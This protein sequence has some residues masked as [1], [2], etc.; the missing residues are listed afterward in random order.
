MNRLSWTPTY[1]KNFGK[2]NNPWN[3]EPGL[4]VQSSQ[5]DEVCGS[6]QRCA[7][8]KAPGGDVCPK[9][10]GWY[11]YAVYLDLS[12]ETGLALVVKDIHNFG[13]SPGSWPARK[14]WKLR[15]IHL[16]LLRKTLNLNKNLSCT[17]WTQPK[18]PTP[19]R[20]ALPLYSS[21]NLHCFA[22]HTIDQIISKTTL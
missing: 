1:I 21:W 9:L 22:V 6:R 17:R 18:P 13:S 8:P 10:Y 19:S 7:T 11:W 3:D 4:L 2:S 20:P 15:T 14:G 5:Q 16:K 12:P